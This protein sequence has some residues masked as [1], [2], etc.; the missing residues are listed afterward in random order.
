[1]HDTQLR[2]AIIGVALFAATVVLAIAGVLP[3]LMFAT[4]FG[5]VAAGLALSRSLWMQMFVLSG[6]A[7]GLLLAL[8]VF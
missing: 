7:V 2:W 4:S 3:W 5:T 8:V 6:P 1:M